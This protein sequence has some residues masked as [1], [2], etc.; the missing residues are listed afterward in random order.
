MNTMTAPEPLLCEPSVFL[1]QDD[2]YAAWLRAELERRART[3]QGKT[4]HAEVMRRMRERIAAW[5]RKQMAE[6]V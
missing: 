4:P 5:E 1:D 3:P 6:T 2:E